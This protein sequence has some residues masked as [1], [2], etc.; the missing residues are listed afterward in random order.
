MA[1][2]SVLAAFAGLKDLL[3]RFHDACDGD[4]DDIAGLFSA[5][6]GQRLPAQALYGIMGLNS[7]LVAEAQA[8]RNPVLATR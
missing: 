8:S 5:M 7:T 1:S 6:S 4:C 2:P 3:S